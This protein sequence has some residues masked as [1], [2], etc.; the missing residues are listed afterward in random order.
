MKLGNIYE[1]IAR[2]W[3]Y[4]NWNTM[5]ALALIN[6]VDAAKAEARSIWKK[7]QGEIKCH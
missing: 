4:K 3:G 5:C 2:E 1:K 7:L 6:E